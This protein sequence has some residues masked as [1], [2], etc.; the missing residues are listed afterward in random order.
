M[1]PIRSRQALQLDGWPAGGGIDSSGEGAAAAAAA[2]RT[3]HASLD[4]FAAAPQLPAP[5]FPTLSFNPTTEGTDHQYELDALKLRELEFFHYYNEKNCWRTSGVRGGLGP[6]HPGPVPAGGD[7]H[8]WPAN[9]RG[10]HNAEAMW[11]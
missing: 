7:L 9:L 5:E 6:W 2:R 4:T 11:G 8:R 3:R 10:Q 1:G